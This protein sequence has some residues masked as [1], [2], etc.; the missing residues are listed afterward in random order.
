[1]R[2]DFILN[3]QGLKYPLCFIIASFRC[4]EKTKRERANRVLRE[5]LN[6]RRHVADLEPN[7]EA[8]AATSVGQG[9]LAPDEDYSWRALLLLTRLG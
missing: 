1:L 9:F 2:S 3:L 7:L 8:T 4:A 6:C 5:S